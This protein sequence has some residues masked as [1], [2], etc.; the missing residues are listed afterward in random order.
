MIWLL[1][2]SLVPSFFVC[3]AAGW[4]VRRF[5][6]HIGLIDRPS[7]RKD[8]GRV[9]PLGGG[10]AVWLGI[11][12]PLAAGQLLVW[13]LAGGENPFVPVP[14][15]VLP[16]L[17]GILLKSGR[18]WT[19]LGGGTVLMLLGLC[20]DRRG[21]AWQMRLAV[22]FCVACAMVF[23]GW[24]VSLFINAPWL[25]G[26]LSVLWIVGLIN[27]FNML[28]NMD[29]LSGGVAAIAATILAAV[30]LL[31][32]D[33]VTNQPQL[34]VG[35]FLLVLVGALLGFL[36]H[37]RPPAKL[38]LGDAGSY[39]VGYLLAIATLTAT[40]AGNDVPKHAILA[41]LCV[42]AVPLYDA[43]TVILIR[44]RGGRSPFE[45]DR[46][47][48]SHRLVQLGMSKGQAVLTIY[49]T[50][51]ACGL[52]ALLLHQVNGFGA[53]VVLLLVGC[54]LTLIAILE[55]TGRRARKKDRRERSG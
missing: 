34:F 37:N 33:P 15:F 19:I 21:L 47:H 4:A 17:S 53:V 48:F 3:Y 14:E 54:L 10:L 46:F 25:T 9:V 22:Q 50:T 7:E 13:I 44:L 42:M 30:M 51:T 8:H 39:L 6:P 12:L 23:M 28:D 52:G 31:A 38:F 40:F 45:A 35:G 49:L 11:V 36:F 41:P 2:G 18:L 5:A 26:T 27:A 20:D 1:F 24:R 29:G 43:S 16:H 55:T 32:P